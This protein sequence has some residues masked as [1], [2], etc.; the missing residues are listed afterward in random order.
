MT[1]HVEA[2]I[3]A[4]LDPAVARWLRDAGTLSPDALFDAYCLPGPAEGVQRTE[5]SFSAGDVA[6]RARVYVPDRLAAGAGCHVS[7]HGGG[8]TGGSVDDPVVDALSRQRSHDAGVVVVS[9]EYR[10]APAHRYPVPLED[11]Y[12]AVQ[13]AAGRAAGWGADPANLS[14]GGASAG[15]NLAAACTLLTRERAGAPLVFQLLE[16]PLVDLRPGRGSW[17]AYGRG[18]GLDTDDLDVA[19]SSYLADPAQAEEPHASPFAAADL[20]GLPPAHVMTAELDP[21][22]DGGERYARRLQAAGVLTTLR[23]HLG[24]VHG[25]PGLTRVWAPARSWQAEATEAL[26]AAHTR[27]DGGRR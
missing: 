7:L 4:G 5:E 11:C 15:A 26:R 10:L 16:V 19:V 18:Y 3:A 24:H 22:R 21:V 2:P 27:P 23:R 17:Q 8:F 1:L 6:L 14:V 13:W 20:A 9:V 12:A 25:S